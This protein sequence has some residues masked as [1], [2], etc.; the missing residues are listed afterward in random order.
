MIRC[1]SLTVKREWNGLYEE[2]AKEKVEQDS[3]DHIDWFGWM[4][5]SRLGVEHVAELLVI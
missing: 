4:Q 1:E 5:D 2:R 3:G